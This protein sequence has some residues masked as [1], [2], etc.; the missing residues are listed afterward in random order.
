[1]YYYASVTQIMKSGFCHFLGTVREKN[2]KEKNKKEK[3]PE[4]GL[5]IA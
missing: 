5:A 1:M 4:F 2:K 3:N